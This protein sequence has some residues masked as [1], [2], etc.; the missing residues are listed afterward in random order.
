MSNPKKALDAIASPGRVTLGQAAILEKI[1]SPLLT[2]GDPP[3]TAD[4]IPSVYVL[5]HPAADIA[6]AGLDRIA[7]DAFD[8]ADTLTP[9]AF[10]SLAQT[11]SRALADFYAM[12]ARPEDG[13]TKKASPA[14]AG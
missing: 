10:R 5:T 7:R 12:L 11:A 6:A 2:V 9:E 14:T 1:G 13:T 8:W 4:L 3:K